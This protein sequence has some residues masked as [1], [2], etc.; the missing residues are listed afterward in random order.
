MV[1]LLEPHM[2]RYRVRKA[3]NDSTTRVHM[4]EVC[5]SLF[6]KQRLNRRFETISMN[7]RYPK[8]ALAIHEIE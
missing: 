3:R 7:Q 4:V 6:G 5:H 1:E 8:R 2:I